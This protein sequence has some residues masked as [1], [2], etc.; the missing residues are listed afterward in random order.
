[1]TTLTW[2]ADSEKIIAIRD[3]V[4]ALG[5]KPKRE[6]FI[7]SGWTEEKLMCPRADG[8]ECTVIINRPPGV[9]AETRLPLLYWIHMGG[10]TIMSAPTDS[11]GLD[12]ANELAK[13]GVPVVLA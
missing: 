6:K 2:E 9:S 13:S 4:S 5:P 7:A 11:Y 1:M 10:F 3:K 12:I 8:G